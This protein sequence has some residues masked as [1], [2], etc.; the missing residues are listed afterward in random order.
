MSGRKNNLIS[1]K[2]FAS[3]SMSASVTSSATNIAYLDNIGVQFNFTGAPVG[4]FQIEV[5]ADY[6]QDTQGVVT[7][8]GTWIPLTLSPAPAANASASAIYV[9][10][11]QLSA[12]WVRT[13]YTV[14]S[15]SGVLS[16]YITAKMV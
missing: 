10:L 5:S 4:T 13:S 12:P 14:T 6:Q 2:T 11:N 1:F 15:G 8:T 9:D 3:V 7:N 16:S